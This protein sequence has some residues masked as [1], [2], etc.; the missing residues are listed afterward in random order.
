MT[1]GDH[2]PV[3]SECYFLTEKD[4]TFLKVIEMRQFSLL[5]DAEQ[6]AFN[7]STFIRFNVSNNPIEFTLTIQFIQDDD[8]INEDESLTSESFFPI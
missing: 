5:I 4:M 6:A 3:N 7:L 2:T 8:V 1:N